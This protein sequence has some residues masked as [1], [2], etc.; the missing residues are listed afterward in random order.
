MKTDK[1]RTSESCSYLPSAFGFS[2]CTRT[3][4]KSTAKASSVEY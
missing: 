4:M 2:I 3:A 1:H